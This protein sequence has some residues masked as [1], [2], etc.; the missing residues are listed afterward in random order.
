MR[1]MV[2]THSNAATISLK[3]AIRRAG[4]PVSVTHTYMGANW[5]GITHI[6]TNL[7]NPVDVGIAAFLGSCHSRKVPLADMSELDMGVGIGVAIGQALEWPYRELCKAWNFTVMDLERIRGTAAYRTTTR[8]GVSV[9]VL[10][11]HSPNC[12]GTFLGK[13]VG[14]NSPIEIPH[15]NVCSGLTGSYLEKL[16]RVRKTLHLPDRMWRYIRNESLYM[17]DFF[18]EE[19]RN[20][21]F[22]GR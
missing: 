6:L 11:F 16:K 14:Q 13:F 22:P 19:E 9:G 5:T 3:V 10:K 17:R 20:C 21:V 4:I 2:F 8:N 1:V 7:R 12:W 15:M 18:S